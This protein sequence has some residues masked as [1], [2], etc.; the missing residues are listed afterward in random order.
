[1]PAS[2]VHQVIGPVTAPMSDSSQSPTITREYL[3]AR[4]PTSLVPTP[5]SQT[6]FGSSLSLQSW[7]NSGGDEDR[8][9]AIGKPT[10]DVEMAVAS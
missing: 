7:F 9:P 8:V 5:I 3:L 10:L 1:M 2:K 4:S 6:S